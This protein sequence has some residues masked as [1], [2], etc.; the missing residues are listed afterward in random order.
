MK[1]IY[2]LF[3]VLISTTILAQ[4]T[5]TPQKSAAVLNIHTEGL[6]AAPALAGNLV[7]IE[8]KKKGMF[9][10]LDKFD[11][12][13]KLT[14][15][16][17]KTEACYGRD[18]LIE[19]GKALGVD[20]MISGNIQQFGK[21]II[22]DLKVIDVATGKIESTHVTEFINLEAELQNMILISVNNL[23]GVEN[24]VQ[25]VNNLI[26]YNNPSVTPITRN[27]NNGMRMGLTYIGGPKGARFQEPT[28]KG[29]YDSYPVISQ[30][31]Y[32]FERVYL[33]AGNFQA[34]GESLFMVGGLE[35]QM[36]IPSV[37]LMNGFRHK[38]NGWEVAF[39]PSFSLQK[40]TKGFYDTEG[41][42][43]GG[44]PGDWYMS[45][46]WDVTESDST[47]TFASENGYDI[48]ERM[49]SRGTIKLST[50]WVWAIGKTFKSGYLNIPVNAYVSPN[51]GGWHYGLSVGFNVRRKEKDYTVGSH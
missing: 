8:V 3:L 21:K 19:A 22:I 33:S 49:D 31:G 16:N 2:S 27:A 1:T 37:V 34:L 43:E 44:E 47:G 35:Q 14:Q 39:G 26:Y 10:M 6:H 9:H 42:I 24:D 20:K 25:M 38:K 11:V 51:K 18:C 30:F 32:Q 41:L 5:Q 45:N 46:Q 48:V 36:F 4:E 29:G 12:G 28:A 15:A 13:D 17:I 7:R 23:F 50:S 40:K